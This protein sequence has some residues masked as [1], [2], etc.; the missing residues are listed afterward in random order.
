MK[1]EIIWIWSLIRFRCFYKLQ[2]SVTLNTEHSR[3]WLWW[4]VID[5]LISPDWQVE[6]QTLNW[7]DFFFVPYAFILKIKTLRE[8]EVVLGR[9]L[10]DWSIRTSCQN[11]CLINNPLQ[12]RQRGERAD[13][14]CNMTPAA[15]H[16]RLRLPAEGVA[17]RCDAFRGLKL[18]GLQV[19]SGAPR[20]VVKLSVDC[21]LPSEIRQVYLWANK[22]TTRHFIQL[23]T[24][25]ES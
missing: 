16:L 12:R 25:S 23:Q 10:S 8:Q 4:S 3:N 21:F 22:T 20:Q 24:C 17:C 2:L 14:L 13:W 7:V 18:N 6:A 5:Q 19:R 15:S 1:L 9:S 11:E